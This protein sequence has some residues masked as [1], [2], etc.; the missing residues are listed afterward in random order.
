METLSDG[1]GTTA[2]IVLETGIT[3]EDAGSR[4][5]KLYKRGRLARVEYSVPVFAS[6]DTKNRQVWMYCLPEHSRWAA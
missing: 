5:S 6:K 1:P 2:D 3:A 4:L